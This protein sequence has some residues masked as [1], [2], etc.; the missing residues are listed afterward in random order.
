MQLPE[1][2]EHVQRAALASA[3]VRAS[4][5][6]RSTAGSSAAL[7]RRVAMYYNFRCYRGIYPWTCS[8]RPGRSSL[9]G[10]ASALMV[11][12]RRRKLLRRAGVDLS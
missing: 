7:A 11:D 4:S 8:L 12:A 1:V 9:C 10:V 3:A 2:Y 6:K 5:T